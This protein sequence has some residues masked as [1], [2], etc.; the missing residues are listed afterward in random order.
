MKL[1]IK[2]Q[3]PRPQIDVAI[4]KSALYCGHPSFKRRGN[5]SGIYSILN[6]M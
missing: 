2:N 3:P 5:E 1:K 6:F 4:S